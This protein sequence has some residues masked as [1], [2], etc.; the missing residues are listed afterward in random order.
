MTLAEAIDLLR[1]GR[2][3]RA[4][5]AEGPCVAC[6]ATDDAI[7]AL[8]AEGARLAIRA[9]EDQ[10]PGSTDRLCGSCVEAAAWSMRCDD[11]RSCAIDNLCASCATP[12]E[13]CGTIACGFALCSSCSWAGCGPGDPNDAC[14]GRD[15]DEVQPR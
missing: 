6:E 7:R 11:P 3:S 1:V 8:V 5:L 15:R 12:C 4:K 13:C 9:I 2:C 14:P 10:R